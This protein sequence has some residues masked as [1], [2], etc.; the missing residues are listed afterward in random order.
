MGWTWLT[1]LLFG[2][3]SRDVDCAFKLI[4]RKVI[5]TVGPRVTSRGATF[6][7]D[8]LARARRMGFTSREVPVTH[9]QRVAGSQTGAKLHVIVRAFRELFRFRVQMWRE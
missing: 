9:R 7:A 1:N 3:V 4:S 5:N 8:F 2:Y 6:S